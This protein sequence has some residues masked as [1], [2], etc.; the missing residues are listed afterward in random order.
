[1]KNGEEAV[2]MDDLDQLQQDLEK[3][4]STNAIRTRFFL[5]EHSQPDQKDG[6]HDKKTHDKVRKLKNKLKIKYLLSEKYFLDI[7]KEEET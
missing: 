7:I 2:A 3:L 4:L 5:G 6:Q 1:M